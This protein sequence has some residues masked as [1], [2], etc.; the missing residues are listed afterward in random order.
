ML[1]ERWRQVLQSRLAG[2]GFK[3]PSAALVKSQRGERDGKGMR[4]VRQVGGRKT[5][6]GCTTDEVSKQYRRHQNRGN[7]LPRDES[8]SDLLACPDDLR[9]KGGVNLT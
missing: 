3:P 5:N 7:S 8:G 4:K 9:H 1:R 2:A 6:A